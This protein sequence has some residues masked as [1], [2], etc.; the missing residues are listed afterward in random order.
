MKRFGRLFRL[1]EG[2]HQRRAAQKR[3]AF[4]FFLVAL[5]VVDWPEFYYAAGVLLNAVWDQSVLIV[6]FIAVASYLLVAAV[7]NPIGTFMAFT[8][9]VLPIDKTQGGGKPG[10]WVRDNVWKMHMWL[11]RRR[12]LSRGYRPEHEK[13]QLT[14]LEKVE[15]EAEQL[16]ELHTVNR[17]KMSKR[18]KRDRIQRIRSTA[19]TPEIASAAARFEDRIDG[20]P[21]VKKAHN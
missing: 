8:V 13:K 11:E 6:F 19:I 16:R 3:W 14:E 18:A 12:Y 20:P 21:A 4:L 17:T 10:E 1:L 5:V 9:L 7:V 2:D 15:L